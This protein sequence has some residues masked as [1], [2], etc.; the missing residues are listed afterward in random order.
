MY[1]NIRSVIKCHITIKEAT[2]HQRKK[3]SCIRIDCRKKMTVR[4]NRDNKNEWLL[5]SCDKSDICRPSLSSWCGRFCFEFI[6][7]CGCVFF[8]TILGFCEDRPNAIDSTKQ[9][10]HIESRQ[11]ITS[12]HF[13]HSGW[14]KSSRR[15]FFHYT[16]APF[17]IIS[18]KI[19]KTNGSK[20]RLCINDNQHA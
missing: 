10:N 18:P 11:N 6:F 13:S 1:L 7:W 17:E 12:H 16:H 5:I 2:Q 4:E 15:F 8:G 14:V 20:N 19:T 9:C 3:I